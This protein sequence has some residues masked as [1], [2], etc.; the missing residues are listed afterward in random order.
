MSV[1]LTAII[2][3]GS[4]GIRL[5]VAE[6]NADAGSSGNWKMIDSASR[7]VSLGRDVFTSGL[8]SR[9]SIL[10]CLSVLHNYR[11]LLSGWGIADN[12]IHVIAT[13]ALR[14]ARNRCFY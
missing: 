12:N 6:I 8:L 11:E 10:E 13:S 5:N 14:A 1:I 3:I 4:T 7:P 2:E 9:E